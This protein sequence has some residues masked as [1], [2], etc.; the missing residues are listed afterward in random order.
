MRM[1]SNI[2]DNLYE[3]PVQ[4]QLLK[5]QIDFM[6]S[7][8]LKTQLSI[9]WITLP[10]LPML[11]T[12]KIWKIKPGLNFMNLDLHQIKLLACTTGFYRQILLP[13]K[14]TQNAM[15]RG[16]KI[17]TRSG[18]QVLKRTTAWLKGVSLIWWVVILSILLLSGLILVERHTIQS[19]LN[20]SMR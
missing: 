15:S 2:R 4:M 5:K 19:L 8:D 9:N 20:S 14:L 11:P 16:N 6:I 3:F 10:Y 17:W 7:C 1:V 13:D 12:T 18:V